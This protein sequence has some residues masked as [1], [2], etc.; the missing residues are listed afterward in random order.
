[1]EYC[2]GVVVGPMFP[3]TDFPEVDVR[4]QPSNLKYG[5]NPEDLEEV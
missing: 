1:L 4:W 2:I 3:N 5:Y